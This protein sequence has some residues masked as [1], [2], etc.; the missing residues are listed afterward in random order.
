MIRGLIGR[1]R[2]APAGVV[3]PLPRPEVPICLIGDIHDRLD[4]LEPLIAQIAAQP[5]VGQ[6]RVVVL[7][8]MIDRGPDSAGVLARLRALHRD[9]GWCCLMG[10]HERMMLDF[11]ADPAAHRR[12]LG[13]GAEATLASLGVTGP[14]D[15]PRAL[16]EALAARLP[17]ET[18]A[19]LQALPVFWQ[20]ER[21]AAVHAGADPS[22]PLAGQ[23]PRN[24]I[25]G[26]PDFGQRPRRDGLWIARGHVIHDAPVAADGILSLDTGA[27]RGGP[28]TAAWLDRDGLRFLS[29][30]AP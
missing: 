5:G 16:A 29:Q 15:R 1:L 8:D 26:H 25:W 17:A 2:G 30:S 20:A 11:L 23:P 6:V 21:I 14:R 7:G 3:P 10:N 12:W 28:L 18:L 19:W 24:L 9:Q 22:R 27:W 4:L 13:F